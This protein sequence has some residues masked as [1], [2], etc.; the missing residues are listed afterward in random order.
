MKIP[1]D[2]RNP[3]I[4]GAVASLVRHVLAH[5]HYLPINKTLATLGTAALG[6]CAILDR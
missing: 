1:T 5:Q 6:G 4:L 3:A 2:E